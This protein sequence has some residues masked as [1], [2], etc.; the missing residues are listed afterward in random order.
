MTTNLTEM[1]EVRS[2]PH[3][4]I[5]RSATQ[6]LWGGQSGPQAGFQAALEIG[7]FVA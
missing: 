4:R 7:P 6:T 2:Q 1:Q 3:Y 5:D